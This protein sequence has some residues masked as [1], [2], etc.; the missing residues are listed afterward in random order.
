MV[1]MRDDEV[2]FYS[3]LTLMREF[4]GRF[5]LR[6]RVPRLGSV[7]DVIPFDSPEHPYDGSAVRLDA[8]L[9]LWLTFS[10]SGHGEQWIFD[11]VLP[12]E[13]EFEMYKELV[14]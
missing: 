12:N 5:S 10:G 1:V 9:E 4:P 13:E 8:K 6:W 3:V 14:G 11:C 2:M 7:G